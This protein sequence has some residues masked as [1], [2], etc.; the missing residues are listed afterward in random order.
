[1]AL[2]A[3]PA[4]LQHHN[5]AGSSTLHVF[6]PMV[7]AVAT[8][9]T[10]YLSAR[11]ERSSSKSS[12]K[13]PRALPP[14]PSD[15]PAGRMI[16]PSRPAPPLSYSPSPRVHKPFI[17]HH[18]PNKRGLISLLLQ[19]RAL[20]TLLSFLPWTDFLAL[21]QSCRSAMKI[22]HKRDLKDVVLA[23][24]VEGYGICLR[25]QNASRDVTQE[26]PVSLHDVDL[27]CTFFVLVLAHY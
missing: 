17:L 7:N 25:M 11:P 3:N 6:T 14:I 27:L 16:A 21:A 9:E 5:S 1:M 19:A 4:P 15:P 20:S 13:L 8:V 23:R 26:V 10:S 24:Y 12:T 2:A 18:S 22:M